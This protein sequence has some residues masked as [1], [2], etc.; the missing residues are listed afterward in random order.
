MHITFT[1]IRKKKINKYNSTAGQK[2]EFYSTFLK[3][4]T[5]LVYR[6]F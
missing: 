6:F 1:R 2:Q 5:P 3:A 4:N